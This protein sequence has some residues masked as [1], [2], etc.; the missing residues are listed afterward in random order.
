VRQYW[1]TTHLTK[2]TLK[3]V[4]VVAELF[5]L[6]T[7][8]PF[9]HRQNHF[10]ALQ[11]INFAVGGAGVTYGYGNTT[12]DEQVDNMETLVA[13]E[14]LTKRHLRNSVAVISIGLNDYDSRNLE[15][16]FRVSRLAPRFEA[17]LLGHLDL[18][19]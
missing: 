6:P 10:E 17:F 2:L 16:P 8:T 14:N 19:E 3:C 18:V 4:F 5:K 15:T 12:L 13:N 9:L 7:P 11:G 1:N